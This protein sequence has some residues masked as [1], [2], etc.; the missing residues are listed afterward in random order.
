MQ[1]VAERGLHVAPFLES[2]IQAF[3][4]KMIRASTLG[5]GAIHRQVRAPHQR[6]A[7][8]AIDRSDSDT[9]ARADQNAM[10]VDV[11]RLGERL[12]DPFGEAGG[13]FRPVQLAHQYGEFVAAQASDEV[14][15]AQ[16]VGDLLAY[17][18]QDGVAGRMPERIVDALETVEIDVKHADHLAVSSAR[19][20]LV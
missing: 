18:L 5:L 17:F 12:H 15:F 7:I 3:L 1:G 16:A 2:R 9:D 19:L 13:V 8:V 20:H 14:A 11:Q 4:I 6:L 10:A